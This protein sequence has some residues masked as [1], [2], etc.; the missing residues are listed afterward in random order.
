MQ[1]VQRDDGARRQAEFGQQRLGC[2]DLVGFRVDVD[3]S[4]DQ[5]GIG[6]ERAEDLGVAG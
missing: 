3:V 4:Q 1:R 5:G 6:G 2:R